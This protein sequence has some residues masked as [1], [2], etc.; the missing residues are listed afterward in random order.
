MTDEANTFTFN[1]TEYSFDDVSDK[2]KYFVQILQDLQLEELK[3][4]KDLDKAT[5]ASQSFSNLLTQELE[6]KDTKE[7]S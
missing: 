2:A 1:N 5:V 7:E 4:R 3:A 6:S